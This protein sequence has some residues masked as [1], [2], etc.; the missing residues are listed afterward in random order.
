M[1]PKFKP[2]LMIKCF[3][4]NIFAFAEHYFE[5]IAQDTG[6]FCYG[7]EDSMR[8]LEMGAMETMIVWENLDVT[9]Y[10]MKNHA[11]DCKSKF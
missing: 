1:Y 6:K 10:T 11:T 8:V 4:I 9:R 5:E 3:L 7:I 2:N